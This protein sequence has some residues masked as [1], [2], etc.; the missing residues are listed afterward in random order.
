MPS[1]STVQVFN[2]SCIGIK[3]IRIENML[4]N[5]YKRVFS[6]FFLGRFKKTANTQRIVLSEVTV[7]EHPPE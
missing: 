5:I 7:Q 4:Y 3:F 2:I 6:Y 1:K